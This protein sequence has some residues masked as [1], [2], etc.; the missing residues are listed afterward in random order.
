[1]IRTSHYLC[2]TRKSFTKLQTVRGLCS[3]VFPRIHV[4]VQL[5]FQDQPLSPNV[6]FS[7]FGLST[8][9]HFNGSTTFA[10]RIAES[11]IAGCMMRFFS[12]K[13]AFFKKYFI[14]KLLIVNRNNKFTIRKKRESLIRRSLFYIF[15][16]YCFLL[17]STLRTS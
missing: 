1:M 11:L 7:S 3:E 14:N 16:T 13:I 4:T 17:T 10:I 12:A 9:T 8:L 15:K 2:I 5:G 6:H